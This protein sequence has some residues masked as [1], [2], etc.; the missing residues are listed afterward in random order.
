MEMAGSGS[1]AGGRTWNR[2]TTFTRYNA[3]GTVNETVTT[4]T[5]G[6]GAPPPPSSAVAAVAESEASDGQ[7]QRRQTAVGGGPRAA[8]ERE[9]GCGATQC[10]VVRCQVGPITT[11]SRV[12]FKMHARV[13]AKTIAEVRPT[14]DREDQGVSLTSGVATPNMGGHGPHGEATPKRAKKKELKE[15]TETRVP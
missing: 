13:W 3:D 8:L 9:L 14:T 15:S 6:V 12:V 5:S 11:N 7:R 2:S 4:T 10:T 1:G